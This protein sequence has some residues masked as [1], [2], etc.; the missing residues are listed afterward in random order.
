MT[1]I[2]TFVAAGTH[3]H[4]TGALSVGLPTGWAEGDLLIIF[5]E[6]ENQNIS[7]PT[8]WTQLNNSPQGSGTAANDASVRLHVF[9][10]YAT[11]SEGSVTVADSGDHTSA[12]MH[13]YR[14]TA[15]TPGLTV[16]PIEA[17]AGDTGTTSTS[18]TF[19]AV[20]TT[21]NN[22]LIVNAIA[23]SQDT[24]TPQASGWTNASLSNVTERSDDYTTDAGG[25]GISVATG[26]LA[27]LGSSGSTTATLANTSVQARITFALR[28][29]RDTTIPF[30]YGG[31]DT[32]G[33]G[34]LSIDLD[35]QLGSSEGEYGIVVVETA[36][37]SL[38]TPSGWTAVASSP[39]GTGTG[40]GTT[41]TACYVFYKYCRTDNGLG[42]INI[43]DSGD[44]QIVSAF[45]VINANPVTPV[46]VEAGDVAAAGT[47]AVSF[48]SVTT[49]SNNCLIVNIG[50]HATDGATGGPGVMTNAALGWKK[51]SHLYDDASGN[52]GGIY[53]Y[54]S[55][56]E[57]AGATGNSTATL[58]T[59]SVQGRI[60]LAFAPIVNHVLIPTTIS[61]TLGINPLTF[62]PLPDLTLE[63]FES[64]PYTSDLVWSLVL[65]QAVTR[66]SSHV[67]QGTY[68]WRCQ[69]L[70][71]D[72]LFQMTATLPDLTGY[73]T[74][75]LDVY[76]TTVDTNNAVILDF[77]SG[78]YQIS[79]TPGTTG[80]FTVTADISGI[81][82]K[83]AILLTIYGANYSGSVVDVLTGNIDFYVDNLLAPAAHGIA[84][85]AASNSGYKAA[86]SSYSWSHT[87]TG[88]DRYLVVGISML[89]LAQTVSGITYNSIAMTLL[90]S[91]NSI[92]GACRVELWGLLAPSLGT[93]TIAVTLTG[94]I[95]SAGN[96]SSYTRVHQTSPIEGFN[97][98]QATNVGAAD[99]TVNVTTVADNDWCV[100]VIATD[101]GSITVGAGQTQAGNVTGAGGSG[102][103]SYEGPKTPAGSVTMSWTGVGAL[104]TWSIGSIALRPTQASTLSSGIFTP[105]YYRTLVAAHV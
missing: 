57:T 16:S 19:P 49:T 102:A 26:G 96:A 95:A 56:K 54:E 40:G 58:G 5:A 70:V 29:S 62:Y 44:H 38:A 30:C 14:G 21:V 7:T 47:T 27:T 3:V 81:A 100:D 64:A 99:A 88:N 92:T 85:D 86:S 68:T 74:V 51:Y 103:M 37:Q 75:T 4:G 46:H 61:Y 31:Y 17:T 59:S 33:T 36:N 98:A 39:Q 78:A 76:V 15:A 12:I 42:T 84:F 13:A 93:N 25:G 89:S 28:P 60:T 105:Y 63:R 45:L 83:T 104:A 67:T 94:A 1:S 50:T 87:C 82:D 2:P 32:G 18:V 65:G 52:G 10:K 69:G 23:G 41:A 80:A 97:S 53:V 91:R 43:A 6:S 24:T 11:S 73:N 48:P 22:C 79:T 90:G 9:Y 55:V 77:N 35:A 101:D 66:T 71:A 34:A 20:T 8:N 72:T